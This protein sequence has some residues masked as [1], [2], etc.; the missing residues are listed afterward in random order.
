MK[1][2]V[3]DREWLVLGTRPRAE[4][5]VASGLQSR[6]IECYLPLQRQLHQWKDRKKWVEVVLLPSYVFVRTESGRRNEVFE[7]DGVLKYVSFRGVP[8]IVP[9]SDIE[10]MRVIC[11]GS[12]P[13][14][15]DEA[16]WNVGD[17]VEVIHGP[18]TGLRGILSNEMNNMRLHVN[19]SG[20]GCHLSVIIDR[21]IVRKL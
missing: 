21:N 15:A 10:R 7:V 11:G 6:G 4:K 8:A 2:E 14:V 16:I 20:L 9:N 12:V 1:S 17:Q 3:T 5:K 18:L 19:I 13:V